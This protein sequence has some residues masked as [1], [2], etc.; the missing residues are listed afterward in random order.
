[1]AGQGHR[2]S[3]GATGGAGGPP[4]ALGLRGAETPLEASGPGPGRPQPL[5]GTAPCRP[6]ARQGPRGAQAAARAPP[7]R[8]HLRGAAQREGVLRQIVVQVV[9]LLAG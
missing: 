2:S 3:G 1:M 7:N 4:R 5:Q 6:G 8:S 9:Q